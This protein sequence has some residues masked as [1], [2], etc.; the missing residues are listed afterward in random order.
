MRFLEIF[1]FEVKY[2]LQRPSTW[3]YFA[4]VLG[5]LL[6]VADEFID[7]ARTIG[8]VL[9]HSPMTVADL[10]GFSNKFGLLLIAALA[11][12]GAM[13]D[14][15]ARMDALVYTTSINKLTYIA[16]RFF[17][18]FFI[19]CILLIVTTPLSLLIANYTYGIENELFG[20]LNI[21]AYVNAILFLTIPNVFVATAVSFS[22]VLLFRDS[23]A[24]FLG[25]FLF[26]FLSAF[27]LDMGGW[28]IGKFLDPFGIT[29][30][31]AIQRTLTSLNANT[32]LL[33]LT[34]ALLAN[35][36]IWPL[37]IGS[38]AIY[39]FRFSHYTPD[40][41]WWKRNKSEKQRKITEQTHPVKTL[42]VT[43]SFD[44][45]TRFQQTRILALN[46]Y[47]EIALSMTGF[48][49]PIYLIFSMFVVAFLNKGPLRVSFLPTT[50][51][52]TLLL[53]HPAIEMV[54]MMIIIF[55]AGQLVW[56]ERDS[57]LSE[58]SDTVPM[59]DTVML[60]SKYAGLTFVIFTLQTLK[61]TGGIL[62]QLLKGSSDLQIRQYVQEVFILQLPDYLL[63]AALAIAVHTIV[64]QKYVGYL[65]VV[66]LYLYTLAP[67]MIG[68]EHKLLIFGSE[69][70]FTASIFYGKA[71][72]FFP[73]LLFKFY[74]V[75][76][77]LLIL[78]IA[79][80]MWVRGRETNFTL[81]L[82]QAGNG[83]KR[84]PLVAVSLVL[85]MLFGGLIFYNINILNDYYTAEEQ[86]EQ[87]VDYERLYGQYRD[88]P[89]P[90]LTGTQLHVDLYPEQQ[91]AQVKGTFILK[92]STG[93]SIDTI[94]VAIADEVETDEIS[95]DRKAT[96]V[97]SDKKLGHLIY[98]LQQPL[99]PGD[100]LQLNFNLQFKPQGLSN[101]DINTSVVH[102]GSWIKNWE[103]LPAVGYQPDWELLDVGL[104]QKYGL[105]ERP[106]FATHDDTEVIMN[107]Y[108][109]EKFDFEIIMSTTADQTAVAPGALKKSWTDGDRKYF[110]YVSD[111]PIRNMYHLYSAHYEVKK[112]KW[113]DVDILIYH[114]PEHDLNVNRMEKAMK[115]S[116]E[117]YSNSLSP[118]QFSQLK[119]VEDPDP[120][121]R[122]IS[123][124]GTMGYS[125]NFALLNPDK[126]I[127]GFDLSFAATAHE[128]AHQWWAHQLIPADVEGAYLISEG[129]AWYSALGVVEREYGTAHLQNLLDA[130][131]EDFLNPRS[132]AD[133]P[134]INAVSAFH[135]YRKGP[136][137]MYALREYIGEDQVDSALKTLLNKFASG[138][139]PY[140]TALDFYEEIKHVTPDSLHYLLKDLF[141]KNTYW[142]LQ[143]RKVNMETTDDGKW[144]V[145]MDV[146]AKKV[147]VDIK[148]V[149]TEAAMNDLI[150]IG[151]FSDYKDGLE[152]TLHMKKYRIQSGVNRIVVKV[153]EKPEEAGIDPRNLLIDT[154]TGDN[155]RKVRE[156]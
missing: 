126:K 73:W 76:W 59:S 79:K 50:D 90:H 81:R 38:V 83:L 109:K 142:T 128:V 33:E 53:G 27:S 148:G 25:A 124:P 94:H 63:F 141:E 150:E 149:E 115:A 139:P 147:Y 78:A 3:I 96:E 36:A 110:H 130:M 152:N 43:R 70:G 93:S 67:E 137:A 103:W 66:L 84:S 44:L 153:S 28:G 14:I 117:Y 31:S 40:L 4:A 102:N 71:P 75:G 140:A 121:T 136:F 69:P 51:R 135:G 154:D 62:V 107:R 155:V 18:V 54:S 68:I 104:R 118:Y 6:M 72:L 80:H 42:H 11:A 143:T 108:N 134:L 122:G 7:Y 58:I 101:G 1:R 99:K 57:R 41:R 156:Y 95:F 2:H 82:R 123:L 23:M 97:L 20:P 112:S 106:Y 98:V 52:M 131:R 9:L 46:F 132:K 89:Q 64:N 74:W 92:N 49:F 16:G 146:F 125:S 19:A 34:G 77:A 45:R 5:L 151:I 24:A 12:A 105:P 39:R 21:L 22:M 133:A 114:H 55:L 47:K 56:R 61:M 111:K 48:I 88:T 13:R 65:G 100:S 32:A 138:E 91:K 17:G 60:S 26:F 129:L 145:T 86:I 127:R 119:F 113:K 15:Q 29:I 87:Q 37:M 30:I 120:G 10:T 144:Q 85:I 116:L 8:G 35:R